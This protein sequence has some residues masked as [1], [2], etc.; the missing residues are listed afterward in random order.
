MI[1]TGATVA[2]AS[3][4]LVA[5]GGRPDVTVVATHGLLTSGAIETLRRLPIHRVVTTDSVTPPP[6]QDSRFHRVT[7]APLLAAVITRLD[8]GDRE[9]NT[10]RPEQGGR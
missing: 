1:S 9:P 10:V 5:A 8:R 6:D 2:A 7:I 3:R 4:A